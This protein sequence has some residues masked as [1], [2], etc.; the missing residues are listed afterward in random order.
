MCKAIEEMIE[1]ANEI[2]LKESARE[3]TKNLI[4]NGVS[5]ELVVKSITTLTEDEIN[6]IYKEVSGL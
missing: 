6:A 5:L 3:T 1:E 4:L 2:V